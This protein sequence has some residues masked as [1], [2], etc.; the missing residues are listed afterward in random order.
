MRASLPTLLPIR[1][2]LI[3]SLI[4]HIL[5]GQLAVQLAR[6][7]VVASRCFLGVA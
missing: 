2:L 1:Q 5:E 4:N 3:C 6:R 7:F